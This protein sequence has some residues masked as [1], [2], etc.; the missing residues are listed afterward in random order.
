MDTQLMTHSQI[1]HML[2]RKLKELDE[3]QNIEQ[4]QKKTLNLKI[5]ANRASNLWESA[6]EQDSRSQITTR[7]RVNNQDSLRPEF[8]ALRLEMVKEIRD[9]KNGF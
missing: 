5:K 6:S 2:E 1:E 7:N 9:M 8:D 4:V 3:K